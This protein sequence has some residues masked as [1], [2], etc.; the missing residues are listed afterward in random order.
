M[1]EKGPF[2]GLIGY[3][4]GSMVANMISIYLR[5]KKHEVPC[6]RFVVTLAGVDLWDKK[7]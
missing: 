5:F 1:K 7:F 6:P 2:H 4:Q 3:S